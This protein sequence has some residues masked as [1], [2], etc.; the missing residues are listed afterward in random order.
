MR[1]SHFRRYLQGK[2]VPPN[3]EYFA[4]AGIRVVQRVNPE[5]PWLGADPNATFVLKPMEN[6]S[7]SQRK[8]YQSWRGLH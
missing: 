6:M 5:A 3:E 4:Y 8:I 2:K 7:D 1:T